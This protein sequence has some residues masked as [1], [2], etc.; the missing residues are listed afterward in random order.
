MKLHFNKF[1][2]EYFILFSISFLFFINNNKAFCEEIKAGAVPIRQESITIIKNDNAIQNKYKICTGDVLSISVYDEQ[3]FLQPEIIVRPDGYATIDPVGEVYV[4]GLDIKELTKILEDKFK[5][6]INEPK[7]SISIKDFNPAS[8]YIFG[9]VQKPGMYQ[10]MIT[11]SKQFADSK[12]PTV[13]TDLTLTNVIG[14]AGGI[15]IDADLSNIKITSTDKKDQ[16]VDLWKFIKDGDISQNAKLKS[17]DVIFVPKVETITINDED[18]QLLTKMSIFP[19]T[20]PVRIVGEIKTAGTYSIKDDSPYLNTAVST[21]AG[22]TLDAN[23]AIII[24][25]RQT[26]NEKLTKIF[27]DPFKQDF[28]LRPNDLIEVRKRNFMKFVYGAD[29]FARI[30]SPLFAIPNVGNSWADLFDPGRRNYIH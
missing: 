5:D 4:E 21:A 13:R 20:F 12:N 11:L 28:V 17:G 30:I 29:Y 24:V 9:A 6:Y 14:N 26:S 10:Q 23:K 27:V 15:S 2:K 7:I 8:I 16:K 1:K 3:N 22:Y 19:A 25:Y 18:F